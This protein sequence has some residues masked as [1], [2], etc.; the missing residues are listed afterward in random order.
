MALLRRLCL[1]MMTFLLLTVLQRTERHQESLRLTDIIASDQ[2]R[3]Y[4]VF[5]KDE[6]QKFLQK[7]RESSLLLLDK[8][9]DP[10][11]YE[12]QS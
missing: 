5:S 11:G 2:H 12:L 8:G 7:M 6:L 1:P 10:L 4:E 9:L 3:L